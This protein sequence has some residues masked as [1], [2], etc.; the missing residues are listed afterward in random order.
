MCT[1]CQKQAQ[2][3]RKRKS[4][5]KSRRRRSSIRGFSTSGVQNVL[6]AQILPGVVGG[7]AASY[8]DKVPG[9][10][11]NPQY[12]NYAGLAIGLA[13]ILMSKNPMVKAAGVGLATV[14]GVKVAA[15]LMD[16]QSVNGIGLFNPGVP[17]F[18][19]GQGNTPQVSVR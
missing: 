19:I 9:L 14:S 12:V 2:V 11:K 10:D 17:A 4:M 15:D 3:G 5:K 1:A 7:L 8:L 18:Q 6:T 13:A 16:G